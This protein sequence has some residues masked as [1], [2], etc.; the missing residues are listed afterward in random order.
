MLFMLVFLMIFRILISWVCYNI[1]WSC[2]LMVYMVYYYVMFG[3]FEILV[4]W[5]MWS[6]DHDMN[7]IGI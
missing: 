7:C 4:T 5:F 3:Y 2:Y 6:T 1:N